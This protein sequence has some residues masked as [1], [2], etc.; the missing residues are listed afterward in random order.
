MLNRIALLFILASVLGTPVLLH[1]S[2]VQQRCA[3][4]PDRSTCSAVAPDPIWVRPFGFMSALALVW[5]A[6]L[7]VQAVTAR[8]REKEL[9]GQAGVAVSEADL[10]LE[11]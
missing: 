4:I 3:S 10:P 5:A 8:R 2:E 11:E 9:L 6:A 1:R 7:F